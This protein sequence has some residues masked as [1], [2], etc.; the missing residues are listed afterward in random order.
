MLLPQPPCRPRWRSA[1]LYRHAPRGDRQRRGC[2]WPC[3]KEERVTL[4]GQYH[5]RV[6]YEHH[7][8]SSFRE[9]PDTD[10]VLIPIGVTARDENAAVREE[11]RGGK[12]VR[13]R[14]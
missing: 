11:R 5:G 10:C 7:W 2:E 13:R 8:K 4:G 14:E 6:M 3:L 12:P 1:R 9:S